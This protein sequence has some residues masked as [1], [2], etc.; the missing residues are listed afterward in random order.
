MNYPS[1]QTPEERDLEIL[2]LLRCE[3]VYL[4]QGLESMADHCSQT[5][6]AL[7]SMIFD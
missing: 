7:Q 4:L 2:N 6:T 5:I 1:I 3:E